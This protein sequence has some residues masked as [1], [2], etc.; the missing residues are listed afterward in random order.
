MTL[1]LLALHPC[2]NEKDSKH[3]SEYQKELEAH[4]LKISLKDFGVGEEGWGD[5]YALA[6]DGHA[7]KGLTTTKKHARNHTVRTIST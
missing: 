7:V 3:A 2:Q 1:L 6:D 5:A 4:G